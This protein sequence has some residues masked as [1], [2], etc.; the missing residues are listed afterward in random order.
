LNRAFAG[1]PNVRVLPYALSDQAGR[2]RLRSGG[3]ESRLDAAGDVEVPVE[4]IDGLFHAKGIA[5]SY[6]K[7]DLEGHDL[8]MLHGARRTI[9]QW[10]PRIA[11]TTYHTP[12][13]ARLM[14]GFL[15]S[16]NPGYR[17]RTKG[18]ESEHGTPLMLH[19]WVD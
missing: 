8:A 12:E 15:H 19:A 11:I 6:L 1:A 7:A 3:L 9:A 14:M 5:V 13:H 18:I 16:V 4:T 10:S 2:Q 17:F